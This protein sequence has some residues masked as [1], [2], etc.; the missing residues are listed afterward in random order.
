MSYNKNI[1]YSY[2]IACCHYDKHSSEW[3]ILLVKKRYTHCFVAFVFGQYSKKDD[4]RLKYL[5]NNMTHQE[6][7]DILSMRFDYLWYKIWLELPD[8]NKTNNID[9]T[10][11]DSIVSAWEL[12]YKERVVNNYLPYTMNNTSKTDSYMKKKSKFESNFTTDNGHRLRSLIEGTKDIELQWEI[13]KGRKHRSESNISCAIREF[14]EETGFGINNYTLLFRTKS[15]QESIMSIGINYIHTY[16]LAFAH[17]YFNPN[18]IFING[19][20]MSEI[21][22]VKWLSLNELEFINVDKGIDLKDKIIDKNSTIVNVINTMK[23]L[24]LC[25]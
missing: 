7:I 17:K 19:K 21:D 12:M 23:S 22:S 6:K 1:K 20:N 25:A 18:N 4:T 9:I 16:Y 5:F 14:E 15:I 3:K 10:N 11:V 8:M 24:R 2:G 13:P